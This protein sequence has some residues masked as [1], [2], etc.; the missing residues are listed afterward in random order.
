MQNT[1]S[2]RAKAHLKAN[3]RLLNPPAE[4]LGEESR[5]WLELLLNYTPA[6]SQRIGMERAFTAWYDCS[7]NYFIANRDLRGVLGRA[8]E[9]VILPF[10]AL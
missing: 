4:S 2:P 1:L 3:H 6:A 10:E 7:P 9:S 8:I 5:K